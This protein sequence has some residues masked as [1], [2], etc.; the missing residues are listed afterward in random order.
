M[1]RIT[2]NIQDGDCSPIKRGGEVLDLDSQRGGNFLT[3]E[4]NHNSM[5]LCLDYSHFS[6]M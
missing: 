3:C 1:I 4:L 6:C 5:A 2:R